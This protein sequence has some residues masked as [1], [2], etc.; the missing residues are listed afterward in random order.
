MTSV[1]PPGS[2]SWAELAGEHAP[3]QMLVIDQTGQILWANDRG[4][5]VVGWA[6]DE[7]VG[8]SIFE[9]VHPD[10]RKLA[11][12]SL[13]LLGSAST[14]PRPGRHRSLARD[15]SWIDVEATAS[16]PVSVDGRRVLVLA[17]RRNPQQVGALLGALA[18]QR[19]VPE[20][21][22]VV[23]STF[24]DPAYRSATVVRFHDSSGAVAVSDVDLPTKLTGNTDGPVGRPA[25]WNLA[26][27]AVGPIAITDLDR[28]APDVAEAARAH[29][30]VGCVVQAI[31]DPAGYPPTC[32][33]RWA[34]VPGVVDVTR[35][36]M[37]G[38]PA[39]LVSLVLQQRHRRELLEHAARHD[40]LTGLANRRQFV[41][42]LRSEIARRDRGG[43]GVALI[44]LDLDGFKQVNDQHG[45]G[46]GD[47]LLR[48]LSERMRRAMRPTD[49][50]ARL[51][52]D[53]FAIVCADPDIAAT[54][55]H[56]AERVHA[57][58]SQPFEVKGIRVRLGASIG[59]ALDQTLDDE[60][61]VEAADQA[62]YQ[63][64]QRGES[65]WVVADG[66]ITIE[67]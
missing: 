56:V 36:W 47:A 4:A 21:M 49:L 48:H 53:E 30:F 13:S 26:D 35:T 24:R 67:S 1:S 66:S 63:A 55:V 14:P 61:L 59:V 41:E 54:A 16:P 31:A 34:T 27:P 22:E 18:G 3:D 11:T 32:I 20:M 37:P 17:V 25:P 29:G 10:D 9:L 62:M 65:G 46:V 2:P 33:M 5:E 15:G 6:A 57:K 44:Y 12:A 28:L 58:L 50:V 64:K 60:A 7:I 19:P 39:H 23:L 43:S 38:E 8:R 52:G 51:G 40:P 42:R 45:H